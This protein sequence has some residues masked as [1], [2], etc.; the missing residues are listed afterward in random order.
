MENSPTRLRLLLDA[1][2]P[3][4]ERA[5][6]IAVWVSAFCFLVGFLASIGI[7]LL[8]FPGGLDL[9]LPLHL[10]LGLAG[11]VAGAATAVRGRQID[12]RRWEI[13]EDPLLTDGERELAHREAERQRRVSG[14][15]FLLAPVA[16]GYWAAYQLAGDG[17]GSPA[18]YLL[19]ASPMLGFVVGLLAA[20]RELGPE[21]RPD[22]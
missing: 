13:L 1:L 12:R 9:A 11:A 20:N 21:E 18:A 17:G 2:A 15:V 5:Q 10:L 8:P 6:R 14:T 3:H 16:L 7:F 22:L 19:T 4:L